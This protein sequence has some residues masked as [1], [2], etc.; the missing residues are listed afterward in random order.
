[1]YVASPR[2][3]E[4][5]PSLYLTAGT[6]AVP[7][8]L[9]LGSV[10]GGLSYA[11]DLTE[12]Q[13]EGHCIRCCWIGT[14]IG[15]ALGLTG[16][17]YE[18][19][20][21]TLLMKDLGCSSN[22]ARI[23]ALYLADDISFKRDFKVIDGSLTEALRFVFT[24]TGLEAG[25][26]ERLRATV[27]ILRNGGEISRELI[28]TRCHRGADIAG[29]MRFSAE[30]QNGIRSLDEHW[31][32]SGKPDGL[33]GADLPQLSN[34]ALMAQV[35]DIF[36]SSQGPKAALAEVVG[37]AGRWFDPTLVD[38]LV[39]ASKDPEFWTR[40]NDPDLE[41]HVF[42]L[43]PSEET[44]A[45]DET[46]LDDIASAFA[47]VVDAKSPFTADHSSRVTLYSDMIAEELGLGADHRRWLRRAALLHDLGKLAVSNQILDKPGKPDEAEW[48]AIRSHPAF[49]RTI[50]E[51]VEA[52]RDIA[53]VAGAHHERLDGGGYPDGVSGAALCLEARILTV[54]DVFD[55]LSADRPYRAAMPI[56]KA[57]GIMAKDVDKAFDPVCFAALERGLARLADA[58]I[59]KE[60]PAP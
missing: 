31:D 13:P 35:T 6:A 52:F 11:L 24:K 19:L 49:S 16:K 42:A 29:K 45:L 47:D 46:Y 32:G 54:A 1:M 44:E 15:L 36:H 8:T 2:S 33:A 27:N 59:A 50:L 22:A 60:T 48:A 17:D 40:L 9:R 56:E 51:R 37:R 38:A 43:D 25:L 58:N 21:F 18:D 28:E 39:T 34:I 53:P 20:Y 10:L 57:L 12:G 26:S 5:A 14:R 41:D 55:A 30:V 23:C 4:F 3:P 7:K